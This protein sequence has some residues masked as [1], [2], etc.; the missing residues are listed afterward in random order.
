V[1]GP[2][3][4]RSMQAQPGRAHVASM[5]DTAWPISGHPPGSSRDLM[6]TPVSMSPNYVSTLHRQRRTSSR[7]PPDTS[8]APFPTRSPRQSSANA[9]VGGLGPPPAGRSRRA[10]LHHPHSTRSESPT[11]IGL[12]S[13][14]G[15]TQERMAARF[16]AGAYGRAVRGMCACC[17][18]HKLHP[19]SNHHKGTFPQRSC[20]MRSLGHLRW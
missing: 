7:P 14:S 9:A 13:C 17:L 10:N 16:A 15:H 18:G 12:P 4:S 11:Y 8:S 3:L 1:S 5:P 19:T 6:H 20:R 2:A